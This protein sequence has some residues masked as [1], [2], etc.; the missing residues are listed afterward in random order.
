MILA[1][2]F[3]TTLAQAAQVFDSPIE[4]SLQ[5]EGI[6]IPNAHELAKKQGRVLR[7]QLPKAH[8]LDQLGDAGVTDILILRNDVDGEQPVDDELK[9]LKNEPRITTVTHIDLPWKEI[10]D[11]REPCR[12][13]VQ[14]LRLIKA[15]LDTPNK[16]LYFHCTVGEDRTGVVAGLYRLIFEN[17]HTRGAF[18]GEMCTRGYAERDYGKPPHV[19]AL[20]HANLT[21]LYLQ[22][23]KLIQMK[24]ITAENLDEN[25]C[26]VLPFRDREVHAQ[27]YRDLPKYN[28]KP[29]PLKFRHK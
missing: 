18:K 8:E 5:G 28:C 11:F 22:M 14:S 23:A 26:D 17:H 19:N 15:T 24:L 10:K 29:A 3:T 2:L 7:G 21:F 13:V 16:T 27:I 20:V 12:Q 9:M 1:F 4:S 6:T 25:A